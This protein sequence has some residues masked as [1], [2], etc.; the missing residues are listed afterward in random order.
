M[1]P[2]SHTMNQTL[3]LLGRRWVLRILWELH[4]REELG[5]AA[6]RDRCEGISTSVLHSRLAD[7]LAAGL[8]EQ[9]APR[10]NYRLTRSGQDLDTA[11]DAIEFWT[12]RWSGTPGQ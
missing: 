9:R 10:G 3:D 6:L 7:L 1:D 2:N 8:V 11:L 5:A 12:T 4:R